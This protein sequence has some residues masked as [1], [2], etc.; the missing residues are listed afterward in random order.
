MDYNLSTM[1][2]LQTYMVDDSLRQVMIVRFMFQPFLMTIIYFRKYVFRDDIVYFISLYIIVPNTTPLG[3]NVFV[4]CLYGTRTQYVNSYQKCVNL[5]R[6]LNLLGIINHS[7][8]HDCSR[9]G[10]EIVILP[11]RKR[12]NHVVNPR[13]NK[14]K[15][16]KF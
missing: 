3:E 9:K 1:L 14:D 11:Y 2:P 7:S 8:G 13:R 5:V 10:K 6:Y 12:E 4:T 16:Y 15:T